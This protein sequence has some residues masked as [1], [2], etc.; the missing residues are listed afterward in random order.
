MRWHREGWAGLALRVAGAALLSGSA[1][2]LSYLFDRFGGARGAPGAF[3]LLLALIGFASASAGSAMLLLGAHLF[4]EI[5]ISA[6][7]AHRSRGATP[8]PDPASLPP[9]PLP[10]DRPQSDI[11]RVR[12]LA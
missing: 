7:W 9:G 10:R 1:I 5:E 12:M 6:R 11:Q 2:V 8:D 3:E 4:D